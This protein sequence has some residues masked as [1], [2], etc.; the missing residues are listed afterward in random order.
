MP[1][2]VTKAN[3]I[4]LSLP[5]AM[6]RAAAAYGAGDFA[7]A[8][9]LCKAIL[10]A[11]ADY[12]NALHLLGVV[13]GIQGHAE[14]G[15]QHLRKAVC[16]YPN[17][18]T[19]YWHM[20]IA[21]SDLKRPEEALVSFD[22]ALELQPDYVE[23][24]VNRGN[25]LQE[26][27]RP[28][29]A[30]PSFRRAIQLRPDF[31][32]AHYNESLCSLQL[33]D[34][35]KGWRA[36]EWRSQVAQLEKA[37]RDFKQ[38][39]WLGEEP[40]AG[41]TILLHAE[42]GLGDTLQFCRYARLVASQ[43]ATVLMEVQPWLKS[44]LAK[45]E[46]VSQLLVSGETLPAFDYHCPLLS[47]PLAFKTTLASIPA[48]VPYLDSD[49][50]TVSK[51]RGKLGEQTL[52]RVGL[53]WS[54]STTHRNDQNRSI[55]LADFARLVSDQFQLVSLQ[56]EVRAADKLVLDERQD[57]QYFG[58]DL[59]DFT[60]TAALV[61]L[62][63]VVITVDTVVAHLAGAMGKPVWILL[64]FNPDWRWLLERD[65]SP[66]YPAARLFRQP[67][68]GDWASVMA[69]L[70]NALDERLKDTNAHSPGAWRNAP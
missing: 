52:P 9:R 55:P 59:N 46:G 7:E 25:V 18:A 12:F 17:S 15:L 10:H 8:E 57:I 39:L 32:I 2:P 44:L 6:Q 65:D 35:E 56:K 4:K 51:W 53:V 27:R 70:K 42:Q 13:Y 31:A 20:G 19:V 21:L 41:K 5:D 29:D 26:L 37:Q 1:A 30:L 43:G 34:L 66:W 22:R 36:H 28:E 62:M 3:V 40:L 58:D 38:P 60:D 16:V 33:G 50:I 45:V 14:L 68:P 61:E 49:P 63:D 54:G 23:A 67:A 48:E 64:A 24:L 11:Q 47:L 69:R